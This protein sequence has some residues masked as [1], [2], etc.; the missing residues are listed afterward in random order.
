MN[1]TSAI[2]PVMIRCNK[3]M[4]TI[5]CWLLILFHKMYYM[6]IWNYIC[7]LQLLFIIKLSNYNDWTFLVHI[8]TLNWF[9]F[10]W[11]RYDK[12]ISLITL[13]LFVWLFV[14]SFCYVLCKLSL[15]SLCVTLPWTLSWIVSPGPGFLCNRLFICHFNIW[16]KE[17]IQHK[18][19]FTIYH[20]QKIVHHLSRNDKLL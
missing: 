4:L 18:N 5:F 13:S 15:F 1:H 17:V 16:N 9:K 2:Y 19:F 11:F 20:S 14:F 7:S 10:T 8:H 12:I 3:T 6:K